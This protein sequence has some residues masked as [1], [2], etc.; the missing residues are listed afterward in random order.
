MLLNQLSVLIANKKGRLINVT[1]ILSSHQIDVRAISIFDTPEF[2]ILRLIV[3]KPD[4]ARELLRDNGYSVNLSK[5]MAIDL[6]D[7]PGCLT[8]VISVLD[9]ND[10][11]IEYMYSFVIQKGQSPMM[12]LKVDDDGKAIECLK[13]ANIKVVRQKKLQ[14]S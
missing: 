13:E 12:L 14:E 10:I 11:S 8:E 2:G 3:D 6:E 5:V 9:Q 4:L 1:K 7:E